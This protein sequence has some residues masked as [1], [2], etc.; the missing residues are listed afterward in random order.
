MS[1]SI[2]TTYTEKRIVSQ[3]GF[4]YPEFVVDLRNVEELQAS[5]RVAYLLIGGKSTRSTL[6][7]KWDRHLGILQMDVSVPVREGNGGRDEVCDFLARIFNEHEATLT[8]DIRLRFKVPS[9]RD[10][11]TLNG[12]SRKVVS[13]PYWVDVPTR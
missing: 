12:E 13:V 2:V 3:L 5:H 1:D 6:G 8:G 7:A 4:Y 9:Q 10:F 11:G